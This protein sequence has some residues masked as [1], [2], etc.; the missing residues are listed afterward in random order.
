LKKH[1]YLI[2]TLP[3]KPIAAPNGYFSC[4]NIFEAGQM[5]TK[6]TMEKIKNH[7]LQ[8]TVLMA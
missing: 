6:G 2:V 8:M 1:F 4:H 7:N 5:V 3:L